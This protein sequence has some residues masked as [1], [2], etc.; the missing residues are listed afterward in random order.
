M[1]RPAMTALA[2]LQILLA[3]QQQCLAIAHRRVEVLRRILQLREN[4][5]VD[6]LYQSD[7]AEKIPTAKV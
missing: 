1:N 3:P 7:L 4:T 2:A 6:P 5:A